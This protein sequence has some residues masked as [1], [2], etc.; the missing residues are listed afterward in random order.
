MWILYDN[1]DAGPNRPRDMSIGWHEAE[2]LDAESEKLT[3]DARQAAG[4]GIA[5]AAGARHIDDDADTGEQALVGETFQGRI[6]VGQGG[7]LGRGGDDQA[8]AG[9][10]TGERGRAQA[11]A[12]VDEQQVA[13]IVA[14]LE[15]KYGKQIKATVHVDADLIGGVSIRIGDEVIDAS[16]RGKLAQMAGA[17]KL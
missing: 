6:A 5:F 17:L 2:I 7:G 14:A 1:R 15:Q 3:G 11:G 16:V 10:G 12:A 9:Q 4:H 13:G 8:V